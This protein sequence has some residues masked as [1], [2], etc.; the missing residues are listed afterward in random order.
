MKS[1]WLFLFFGL[2]IASGIHPTDRF[3]WVLEVFPAWIVFLILALTYK[4]FPL[5][6]I[7]Y[8]LILIHA[9]ILYL[10]GRYT[11]AEVPFGYW[12]KDLFHLGRNDYDKIGHFAQGF[13]PALVLREVF[14]RTKVVNGKKWLAA[15]VVASCLAFSAFYELLEFVIAISTGDKGDAFLGTQGYIWDT[16]T[17]MLCAL[18]GAIVSLLILSKIHNRQIQNLEKIKLPQ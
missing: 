3:T 9:S 15:L 11:Y 5:T 18:I 10:G 13:V 8:G 14:I 16:Q 17:D 4:R 6:P 2:M 7:A 1:I 12:I